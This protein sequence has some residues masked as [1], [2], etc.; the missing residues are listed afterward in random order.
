MSASGRSKS[1]LTPNVCNC[2]PI[3]LPLCAF[4]PVIF[5]LLLAGCASDITDVQADRVFTLVGTLGAARWTSVDVPGSTETRP[6]T[7]L[8][9]FLVCEAEDG[10]SQAKA[11]AIIDRG[12]LTLRADG[13]AH[14]ELTAGT[15]WRAG[16]VSGSSSRTTS[17]LGR[18]TES[19]S[20]TIHLSGFTTV[21]FHAPFQY[22][23]LG[24]G[25]TAMMFDCPG[26][27]STAS[28]TP[29]LVFSQAR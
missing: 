13:S 2:M 11:A 5:S 29:Q 9:A 4:I 26:G 20:G 12:T 3:R 6:G 15:W 16:T 23:E 14:L 24:S 10:S 18:W 25:L 28:L 1:Q 8:P 17:E 27:S 22:T 19:E 7:T 21:T